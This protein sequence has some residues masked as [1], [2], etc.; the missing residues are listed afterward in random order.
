MG[1]GA[2]QIAE[3]YQ[4]ECCNILVN[5]VLPSANFNRRDCLWEFCTD[6]DNA[7]STRLDASNSC[8]WWT[9]LF[10]IATSLAGD[11]LRGSK[12]AEGSLRALSI[13]TL[14]REHFLKKRSQPILSNLQKVEFDVLVSE[15]GIAIIITT[16]N[17]WREVR[18]YCWFPF[19]DILN[20]LV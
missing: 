4:L 14:R 11:C 10:C 9:V 16:F 2:S 7:K 1:L 12:S 19:L 17:R 6:Q 15:S 13:E 18:R 3:S 5:A 8:S 20:S